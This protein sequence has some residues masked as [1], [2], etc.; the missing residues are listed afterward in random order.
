MVL[1]VCVVSHWLLDLIVHRPDL[2]L[3]PGQSTKFG[4][5]LWNYPLLSNIIEVAIFV[6]GVIIYYKQTAPKNGAGKYGLATLVLLLAT[7]HVVNIS[8]APPPSV[9]AI[10]WAGQLQW[11]FVL[12][13]FWVDK[14]RTGAA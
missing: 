14:N 12:L 5:G 8:G 10:A 2:P 1:A 6:A 13:A 7:I 3:Y 11:I 4:F 9:T